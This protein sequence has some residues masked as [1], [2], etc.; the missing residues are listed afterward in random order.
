MPYKDNQRK[1]DY[2]KTYNKEKYNFCKDNG[3]CVLCGSVAMTG[4][5]LCPDCAE[6]RNEQSKEYYYSH[7]Q[8][9]IQKRTERRK[10]RTAEGLCRCCDRPVSKA[11]K[12]YC[13]EHRRINNAYQRE[14]H[15]KAHSDSL[16]YAEC[17]AKGICVRCRKN[18]QTAN[19]TVCEECLEKLR[20]TFKDIAPLGQAVLKEM[21]WGYKGGSR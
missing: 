21:E 13:E 14:R 7:R 18:K 16:S 12:L 9:S 10:K 1:L 15:K 6:T 20:A 3:L 2:A 19:R 4:Y 17:K 8:E 11:N 5:T